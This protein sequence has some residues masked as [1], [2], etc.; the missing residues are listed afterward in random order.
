M[1]DEE[2]K[3]REFLESIFGKRLRAVAEKWFE[4]KTYGGE[5]P[6]DL[7]QR[8]FARVMDKKEWKQYPTR[9][10]LFGYLCVT[11]RHDFIDLT[12]KHGRAKRADLADAITSD[13]AKKTPSQLPE[14]EL[15]SYARFLKRFFP[16]DKRMHQF[17]D[18]W[19]A[20]KKP[21]EIAEVMGLDEVKKRE[22][23][24]L[25]TRLFMTV[26]PFTTREMISGH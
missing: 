13:P 16:G 6:D 17:I 1:T 8:T 2:V 26:R 14:A 10:R 3:D 21:A 9:E 12:R 5:G 22:V 15:Q 25:R 24:K 23:S 7:V 20:Q 11:M 4:G 18:L 19:L